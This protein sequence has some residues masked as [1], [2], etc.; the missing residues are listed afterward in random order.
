MKI[1]LKLK[2]EDK[3]RENYLY[4]VE[5]VVDLIRSYLPPL[6]LKKEGRYI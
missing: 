3:F 6:F 5:K 1:P 2:N 4:W